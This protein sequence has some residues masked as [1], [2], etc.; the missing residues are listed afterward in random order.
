MNDRIFVD[1]N[2]LIYLYSNDD[3]SKKEK[4]LSLVQQNEAVI[5]TQVLIEF[6]NI[7][8]RKLHLPFA[9]IQSVIIELES[10]FEVHINDT[11]TIR[12]AVKIAETYH[13]SWFDSLIIASALESKCRILYSEDM[14]HQ[15]TL[16]ATLTIINPF[17]K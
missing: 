10:Q 11:N 7:C 6:T 5:S 15:H 2:I 4:A 16:E 13:Y 9:T 14:H 8:F 3:L 1:T 17:E 12:K